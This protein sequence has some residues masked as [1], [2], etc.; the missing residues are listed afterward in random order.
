MPV[1]MADAKPE[2][3]GQAAV[4][5]S[6]I[7]VKECDDVHCST[8]GKPPRQWCDASR[9]L[10]AAPASPDPA[11]TLAATT[12]LTLHARKTAEAVLTA[13]RQVPDKG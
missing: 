7:A 5:C 8:R 11:A 10:G 3:L 12:W 13:H 2:T 1:C 4:S 9:Y 6:S